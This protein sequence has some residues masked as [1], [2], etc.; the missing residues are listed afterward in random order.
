RI[1]DALDIFRKTKERP[2]FI[3][4]DSHIG[5][6]SPHKQDTSAAH[7]E[8]L[9]DD[10]VRLTKRSYGWPEDA[11]FLVPDGVYEH[12]A[13]GIGARGAKTPQKCPALS[14][15]YRPKYPD[16]ATEIDK[17][18]RRDP[19]AGWDRNLPSFPA[20][21]KGIAGRDASGKVLN[22]LAQNIPWFLGG[23]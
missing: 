14:A 18:Q 16:P 2:T 13:A 1:E 22:V 17:I 21:P 12:F 5:Y 9:G 11:K 6:G 4:L 3:V 20:D 10:E 19:P 15:A 8:P 23:S 7:G